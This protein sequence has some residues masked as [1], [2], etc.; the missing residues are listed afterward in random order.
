MSNIFEGKI[1]DGVDRLI[2][3][4]EMHNF[5]QGFEGC[6]NALDDISNRWH[7]EGRTH[8]AEI[9]REVIRELTGEDNETE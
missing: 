9:I 7:N 8:R 4:L 5:N 1:R 2:D 6:I 3:H